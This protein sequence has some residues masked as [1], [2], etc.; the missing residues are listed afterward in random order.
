[1][2]AND[3][4]ALGVIE[5]LDAADRKALVVGLNGTK[6]GSTR[7]KRGSFWRRAIST[8]TCRAASAR[9]RPSATCA[10]LPVPKEFNF[11]PRVI[12]RTNYKAW[13]CR[14]SERQCPHGRPS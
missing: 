11:P 13:T 14:K 12:D 9:W 5:A 6:E 8:G 3:A 4:M 7:S 1:M 10:N 2:A